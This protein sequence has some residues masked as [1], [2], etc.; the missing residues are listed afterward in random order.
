LTEALSCALLTADIR[1][2]HGPGAR[3]A[4]DDI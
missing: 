3:C 1:L 4:I 2:A